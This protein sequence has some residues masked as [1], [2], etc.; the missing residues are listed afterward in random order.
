MIEAPL[1]TAA[2]DRGDRDEHDA[3][4][5]AGAQAFLEKATE[6]VADIPPSTF[7]RE[8]RSAQGAAVAADRAHF[9]IRNQERA[10]APRRRETSRAQRDA[11]RSTTRAARGKQRGEYA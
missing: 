5:E 10:R 7:I 4:V 2:S 9:E 1:A 11:G 3:R 6:S 8:D